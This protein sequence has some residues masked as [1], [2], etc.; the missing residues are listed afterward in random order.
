MNGPDPYDR[1]LDRLPEDTR[2][3]PDAAATAEPP[4]LAVRRDP[5]GRRVRGQHCDQALSALRRIAARSASSL[6][7]AAFRSSAGAMAWSTRDRTT[8]ETGNPRWSA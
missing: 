3:R 4:A 7:N 2:P 5:S 1:Q 8:V 6:S